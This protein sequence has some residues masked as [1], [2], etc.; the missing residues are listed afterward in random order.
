LIGMGRLPLGLVRQSCWRR[1]IRR[2]TSFDGQFG[3]DPWPFWR[4]F[5]RNY[6]NGKVLPITS[7][8]RPARCSS[9]SRARRRKYRLVRTLH[10]AFEVTSVPFFCGNMRRPAGSRPPH[11]HPVAV[12]ADKHLET[13]LE[14]L[15]IHFVGNQAQQQISAFRRI[16]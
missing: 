4:A 10:A 8:K 13:V 5:P 12:M 1:R 6:P 14:R 15:V 9:P 11:E 7:E 2:A 3:N 16:A